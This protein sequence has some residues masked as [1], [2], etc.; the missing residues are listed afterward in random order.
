[1]HLQMITPTA[2]DW[3]ADGD[4]DLIVGD[5][6]GRVALVENVSPEGAETPSS[7]QPVYFQQEA[8][9]LK[10]GALATPFAYDWDG[11][12]DEDILC[13]N[14][15][16]NIAVF[17]NL[18]GTGAR[19]SAPELLRGGR[20]GLPHPRREQRVDPG[21]AEAKWGYTT[22]SVADWDGDGRDDILVNSIWPKLQLLRST[23]SGLEQQPLPFW[24]EAEAPAFYWWQTGGKPPDP[25]AD[26][27]AGHR[28]RW[29]WPA[30][31]GDPRPGG[32][33]H[34][35]EPRPGRDADLPRRRPAADPAQPEQRR[36]LRTRETGGGR[37]GLATAASIS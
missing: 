2:I 24:T 5:E 36:A 26:Y 15:A 18:D 6:D 28:L 4:V 17:E 13:G 30:R 33:P 14:T 37:L 12:G 8:D 32:L 7:A 23:G 21:P 25:V 22:L 29:R 1:M 35:P 16:G 34:L 10:F 19:W 3:D 31:S 11:D 9:E 27:P 20:P